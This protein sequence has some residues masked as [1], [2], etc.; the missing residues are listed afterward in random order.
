MAT[1]R[2]GLKFWAFFARRPGLYRFATRIAFGALS[3][4]GRRSGG[5]F[6]SLPLA[7]GWTQYRDMP[8][9]EGGTF[10]AQWKA[11]KAAS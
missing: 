11:R 3:V 5:R 10:M 8:A 2:A 6:K 7:G 1:Q 9:P 4:F